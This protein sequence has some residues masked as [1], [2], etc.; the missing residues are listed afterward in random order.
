M[1]NWLDAPTCDTPTAN[2]PGGPITV[3]GD[4]VVAESSTQP[5]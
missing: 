2:R 5:L 3:R 1:K 4:R